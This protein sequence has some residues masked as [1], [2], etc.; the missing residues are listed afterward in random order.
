MAHSQKQRLLIMYH[1]MGGTLYLTRQYDLAIPL[2]RR[3][4]E[5]NSFVEHTYLWLAAS[6][7]ASGKER[8]DVLAILK[9]GAHRAVGNQGLGS[10]GYDKWMNLPEFQNVVN[11][12]DFLDA[13][14]HQ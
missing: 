3:A 14:K 13:V 12:A 4:V 9:H 5:L 1:D 2:L 7:W 10:L 6:L 8:S 11:D